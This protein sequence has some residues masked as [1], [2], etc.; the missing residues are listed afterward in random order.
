MLARMKASGN[1][2]GCPGKN[3][4]GKFVDNYIVV[5]SEKRGCQMTTVHPRPKHPDFHSP[6]LSAM[7]LFTCCFLSP[8]RWQKYAS[9]WTGRITPSSASE[10][11]WVRQG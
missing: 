7:N 2:T 1:P 5:I 10:Q 3:P 11:L 4:I 6:N 8:F 9:L